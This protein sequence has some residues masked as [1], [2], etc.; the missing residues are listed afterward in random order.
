MSKN[1]HISNSEAFRLLKFLSKKNEMM[2]FDELELFHVYSTPRGEFIGLEQ[3]SLN[4]RYIA[5]D[6]GLSDF[7][8][9]I[10]KGYVYRDVYNF[11]VR[12]LSLI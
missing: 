5:H 8:K 11:C 4:V 1:L 2:G 12:H 7:N 9:A 3:R 10:R 6:K